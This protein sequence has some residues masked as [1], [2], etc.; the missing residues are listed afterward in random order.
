MDLA[1]EFAKRGLKPA[2]N[3][4]TVHL[5]FTPWGRGADFQRERD[6][7]LM[8]RILYQVSSNHDIFL[9]EA[10]VMPDHVH[11]LVSFDATRNLEQDIVKN[12]KGASARY[13]L[14]ETKSTD[15]R[16]WGNKKHFEE[17]TSPQQFVSVTRYIQENPIRAK[18]SP[19]RRVLSSLAAGFNPPA[20]EFIPRHTGGH[21]HLSHSA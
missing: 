11:L 14:Q 16:L 8:L 7:A 19:E 18:I 2:T 21:A 9:Q 17:I 1:N 20:A 10:A 3:L 4:R 12:L 6:A 15:G 13:F 5:T